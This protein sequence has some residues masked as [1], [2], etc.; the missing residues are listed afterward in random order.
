[1]QPR[2]YLQTGTATG[3]QVEFALTEGNTLPSVNL[4]F[5]LVRT[6]RAIDI[7]SV[8]NRCG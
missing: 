6:A 2:D 3:S 7:A 8:Q 1:L 4:T 5:F